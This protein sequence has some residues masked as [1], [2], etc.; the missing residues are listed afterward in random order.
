MVRAIIMV[1][2]PGHLVSPWSCTRVRSTMTI[3]MAAM[4]AADMATAVM[5]MGV[6]DTDMATM[7]SQRSSRR[8]SS[9]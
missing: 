7:A 3:P 9:S 1:N 6:A 4:G 2:I 8:R 5:D